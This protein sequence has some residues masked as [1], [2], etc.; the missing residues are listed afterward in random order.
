MI[1]RVTCFRLM[2]RNF[3]L[4]AMAAIFFVSTAQAQTDYRLPVRPIES[5]AYNQSFNPVFA[6]KTNLLY[7]AGTLTPNLAVE[8]GVG[9]RTSL[10]IFGSYNSWDLS[11]MFEEPNK[12][13][14][15]MIV[16]PEFRYWLRERYNGHF[17]GV[18]AM[19]IDYDI[20][21][22]KVPM[23]FEKEFRYDGMAIGGGVTYGYHL[24]LAKRIGLE[25]AVSAGALWMKHDRYEV[26]AET[27]S[28][29]EVIYFGPTNAAIT[30]VF[31]IK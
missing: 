10:E 19:Y 23:L 1:R 4:P 2:I 20:S 22:C 18:N 5:Y 12:R 26:G 31:L 25:F 9:K 3:L 8:V 7:G 11:E 16:R 30:L 13:L 28:P 27:S 6:I 14:A 24:M 17:F 21:A 29:F 15:H